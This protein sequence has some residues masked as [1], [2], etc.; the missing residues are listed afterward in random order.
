MSVEGGERGGSGE[1]AEE[2]AEAST[3]KEALNT[4]CNRL[5]FDLEK[6]WNPLKRGLSQRC[7]GGSG[8]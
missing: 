2:T 4:M 5:G 6:I 1:A 7:L 8:C 3:Q